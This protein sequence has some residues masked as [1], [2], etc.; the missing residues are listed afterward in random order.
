M[1]RPELPYPRRE[2]AKAWWVAAMD[3]MQPRSQ[4]SIIQAAEAGQAGYGGV[5]EMVMPHPGDRKV[6]VHYTGHTPP[7]ATVPRQRGD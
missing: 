4:W 6:D 5:V 3:D 2:A 7:R 1:P